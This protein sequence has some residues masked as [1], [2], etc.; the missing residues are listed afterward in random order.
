VGQDERESGA[1]ALL[2]LGHTFGHAIEAGLS[3]GT[4][5]HGEAVAAGSVLAA[6]LSQRM[7]MLSDADVARIA[8][9]FQRAQL[10]AAAPDLGVD[11][12]LELMGLDKKVE[13]GKLRLILL[14]RI[15][16]AFV[17]ADFPQP[18][19]REVLASPGNA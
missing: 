4:W 10:P 5:L 13:G 17:T 18:G 6:R 8:A 2:N 3:Y 16:E 12:Y 9:L 15:G 14:H 1:R 11:R 19:L 7:G